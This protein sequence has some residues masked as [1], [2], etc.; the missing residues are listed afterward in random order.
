LNH[1]NCSYVRDN[2]HA[3]GKITL[4]R[5][6]R[7]TNWMYIDTYRPIHTKDNNYNNKDTLL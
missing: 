3:D 5:A 7:R 1:P 2:V 6:I 4:D